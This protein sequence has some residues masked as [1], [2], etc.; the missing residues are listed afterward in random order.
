MTTIIECSEI[1]NKEF[2]GCYA[3]VEG[4][5]IEITYRGKKSE[6]IFIENG[7]VTKI[8]GFSIA[9]VAGQIAERFNL[10]KSF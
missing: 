10:I 9:Q 5:R 7:E 3:S 8:G 1:I 6:K 2:A 4:K